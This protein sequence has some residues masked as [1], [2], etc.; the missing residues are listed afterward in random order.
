[1]WRPILSL[2]VRRQYWQK[3]FLSDFFRA[4]AERDVQPEGFVALWKQL[5][6]FALDEPGWDANGEFWRDAADVVVEL[7]GFE[8]GKAV[9]G[10]DSRY[11][12]PIAGMTA[13]FEEAA[14][15][16]F[17]F[18]KVAAGFCRFSLKPA[19]S[20]LLLP[21]V[22]WL[23]AAEPSWSKWC[24]E[25]DG[26]AKDLVDALWATLERHRDEVAGNPEFRNAFFHLCNQLIARGYQAALA[27]RE[28]IAAA[29][30][31]ENLA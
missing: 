4:A 13:L 22:C 17:S 30:G 19:G 25:H 5:V 24:W 28:R 12:Q 18:G 7:L 3:Y 20:A 15:R 26:L 1:L 11:A 2:G 8:M 16:W 10:K 23:A 29:H 21:G 14:S 9:F 31:K 27:L 6:R